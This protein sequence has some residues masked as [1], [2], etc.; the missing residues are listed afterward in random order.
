[1]HPYTRLQSIG[2]LICGAAFTGL[3]V[4]YIMIGHVAQEEK[5]LDVNGHYVVHD[6]DKAYF[7]PM[8]E[9]GEKH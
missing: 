9:A 1:M 8:P 7:G 4:G 2:A 6:G 5:G 3:L